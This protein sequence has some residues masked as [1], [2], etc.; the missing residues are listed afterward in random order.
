MKDT[1][2]K[3]L[4]PTAEVIEDVISRFFDSD[5]CAAIKDALQKASA[6]LKDK[7]VTLNCT[8]NVFDRDRENSMTLLE[9]GITTSS[10]QDPYRCH[11]DATIQRYLAEGEI[12]QV[13]H[14][15]CPKCWAVWDFKDKHRTCP[16]CGIKLGKEVKILLDSNVC[17]NC[18]EATVS[19]DEP[20][21]PKCG[22]EVDL[23]IV[24]WG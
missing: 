11:D 13:P 1:E 9:M 3:A 4:E 20:I 15:H 23:D 6:D 7:S 18:E 10:G 21:C 16:S 2:F 22:Y 19:I 17:P 24:A 8:V 12:C 5:E 14:D